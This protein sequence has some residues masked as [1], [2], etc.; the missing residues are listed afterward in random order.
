MPI[1]G[2]SA[3]IR[4][5][6]AGKALS[7][8]KSVVVSNTFTRLQELTPY[9]SMVRNVRIIEVEGTW[10]NVHGV[11]PDVIERMAQ[12]WETLRAR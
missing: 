12:R 1:P 4:Q 2:N 9:R 10:E 6:M 5:Q 3:F 7:R 11:P 8:S